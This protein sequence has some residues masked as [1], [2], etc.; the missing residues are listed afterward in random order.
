MIVTQA[1]KVAEMTS[2]LVTLEIP[3]MNRLTK[4]PYS[5]S[6]HWPVFLNRFYNVAKDIECPYALRLKMGPCQNHK[7]MLQATGIGAG[8]VERQCP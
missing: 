5:T 6:C 8:F 4:N 3:Y 2:D 7:T 1:C